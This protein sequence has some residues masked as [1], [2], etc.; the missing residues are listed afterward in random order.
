MRFHR[1]AAAETEAEG[2]RRNVAAIEDAHRVRDHAHI[3]A[4]SARAG[5][6][7]IGRDAGEELRRAAR[8]EQ[9]A[10]RDFRVAARAEPERFRRNQTAVGDLH[11]IGSDMHAPARAAV[12]GRNRV[13]KNPGLVQSTARVDRHVLRMHFH[14]AAVPAT[15]RVRGNRAAL[16][17]LQTVRAHADI[18]AR[19]T[20]AAGGRVRKNSRRGVRGIADDRDRLCLHIDAAPGREAERRCRD[21]TFAR[22]REEACF[23]AHGAG[24]LAAHC[25]VQRLTANDRKL[26]KDH[27][28]GAQRNVARYSGA[29][30]GR[31]YATEADDRRLAAHAH[32]DAAARERAVVFRNDRAAIFH[33]LA[34]ANHDRPARIAR[35]I[36]ARAQHIDEPA[37]RA[38]AIRRRDFA[39]RVCAP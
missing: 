23:H 3:A 9:F 7:R 13:G 4:R 37:Q 26:R 11:A 19:A 1:D 32:I 12:G 36:G 31:Q 8:D 38:R 30:R 24:T 2:V 15:K 33:Q 39:G 35:G 25:G 34:T 5:Q 20:V 18:A 27:A 14:V 29:E 10:R 16:E 22:D 28:A 17:N 21:L 6:R